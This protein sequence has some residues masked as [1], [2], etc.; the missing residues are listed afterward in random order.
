MPLGSLLLAAVLAPLFLAA[1]L[2]A[3]AAAAA[4]VPPHGHLLQM[5]RFHGR[6]GNNLA[7]LGHA[8]VFAD[9]SGA[10]RLSLRAAKLR[11]EP[12]KAEAQS[13]RDLL[14]LFDLPDDFR[15][16]GRSSRSQVS[17]PEA[18]DTPRVRSL[19][20]DDSSYVDPWYATPCSN[21]TAAQ[22]HEVLLSYLR[23]VFSS[24]LATCVDTDDAEDDH[25]LL[26]V[27]LR[28]DDVWPVSADRWDRRAN[29][30]IWLFPPCAMYERIIYDGHFSRVL[31]VTSADRRHP[32]VGWFDA[33][34]ARSRVQVHVQS[35]SVIEDACALL[36]ARHLAVSYSSFGHN[37]AVL[38]NRVR[39]IYSRGAFDPHWLL[40][41]EAWPG[42]S[43]VRYDVPIDDEVHASYN[44]TYRAAV[45]WMQSFPL[46]KVRGPTS[47]RSQDCHSRQ[48]HSPLLCAAVP[49]EEL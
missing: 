29:S 33:L 35:G 3:T 21:I 8:L 2:V 13:R 1:N 40:D 14:R 18:C 23:P 28:G 48:E 39:K 20:R 17:L 10:G 22:Y 36:R 32:C 30:R 46:E 24:H 5:D 34:A 38:S 16:H 44:D 9:L 19:K 6:I 41:C 11:H 27:H 4:G 15:I 47:C 37:L 31:V 49:K 7:Q 12:T 26:T 45:E 25:R 42:T 43:V